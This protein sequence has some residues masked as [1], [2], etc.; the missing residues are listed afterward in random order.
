MA[1]EEDYESEDNNHDVKRVA[2]SINEPTK[3]ILVELRS[4]F[5]LSS[6]DEAVMFLIRNMKKV[7]RPKSKYF[8]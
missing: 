4:I 6:W 7:Q 1:N 2:I 5:M 3:E 8:D